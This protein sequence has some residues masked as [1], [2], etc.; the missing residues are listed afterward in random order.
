MGIAL[1]RAY[2]RRDSLVAH[3][4]N[5][6]SSPVTLRAQPAEWNG[7]RSRNE[8]LAEIDLKTK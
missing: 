8:R 2:L 5:H 6:F 3:A 4:S 1:P 7:F